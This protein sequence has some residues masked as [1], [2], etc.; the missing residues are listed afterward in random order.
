MSRYG[1]LA[2]MEIRSLG[3]NDAALLDAAVRAFRGFGQR[4]DPGFLA[5][6]RAVVL[7]ALDAEAVLGWAWGFEL[8]RPTGPSM[9]VLHGM[10]VAEE[11]RG[12]GVGRA[13]VDAFVA[14]AREGDRATMWLLT[15]VEEEVARR[16]YEGAGGR[17]AGQTGPWWVFE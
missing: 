14:Y 5:D 17:P 1:K 8:P 15:G 11:G 3:P 6:P 4:G 13:I 10:E 12:R 2:I 9:L 7:V 16:L